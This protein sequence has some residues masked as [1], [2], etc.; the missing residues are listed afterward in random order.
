MVGGIIFVGG[1]F[2]TKCCQSVTMVAG[3]LL[4]LAGENLDME[5][6]TKRDDFG[7]LASTPVFRYSSLCFYRKCP[8]PGW[9]LAGSR[10]KMIC[11]KFKIRFRLEDVAVFRAVLENGGGTEHQRI[12]DLKILYQKIPQCIFRLF[13]HNHYRTKNVGNA[14]AIVI[15]INILNL[16]DQW[17][18]TTASEM[19]LGC[20]L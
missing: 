18:P 19:T 11:P 13:W 6:W 3:I 9:H 12:R 16:F 17:F 10:K 14:H 20:S 1:R 4:V 15:R 2:I 8:G 5:P 7:K